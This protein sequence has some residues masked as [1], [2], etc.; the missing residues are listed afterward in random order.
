MKRGVPAIIFTLLLA[1]IAGGGVLSTVESTKT[2]ATGTVGQAGTIVQAADPLTLIAQGKSLLSA[3]DILD[4]RNTFRQAVA[5]DP[6]NQE[7]NLLYGVTRVFAVYEDGQALNT[8]GLDSV[9]EILEL[10]GVVFSSFNL[11]DTQ[12]TKPRTFA[13]TTPSTGAVL[14]FLNSKLLPEINGAIANLAMVTNPSFSSVINPSTINKGTGAAITVDYADALVISS[15]L[16]AMKCNL[17]LLMVYGLDASLP[18]IQAAPKQLM[19]Y[20]QLFQDTTFLTPKN[21]SSLATA[22]TALVAFIDTYNAA[23]E[24]LKSRSGAG[25]HL[26]V[27]DVPVTDEVTSV[28]SLRLDKIR[29]DLADLKTGLNGTYLLP[30]KKMND[31]DR[32]IDLSK[33][34]NS[35][36]PINFRSQIANC[37]SKLVLPDPTMGGLFPLGLSASASSKKPGIAGDILGVACTGYNSETPLVKFEPNSILISDYYGPRPQSLTISNNGTANLVVSAV[38]L[39]GLNSSEFNFSPGNCSSLPATLTPGSSCT[40][41]VDLNNPQHNYLS[42]DIQ[43]D[44]NDVSSPHSYVHL[45]GYSTASG[46]N[47]PPG[48]LTL[49]YAPSPSGTGSGSIEFSVNSYSISYSDT[50]PGACLRQIE[51]GGDIQIRP[52]PSQG[53]LFAGWSGCDSAEGDKC[54]VKMYAA[55]TVNATFNRDTTPLT[56]MAYPPSG[57]YAGPQSVTLSVSK[58]ATIYYTLDNTPPTVASLRYTGPFSITAPATLKY[59]AIDPFNA[60][61]GVKTE[62]YTALQQNATLTVTMNGNGGGGT[63]NSILPVSGLIICSAPSQS[64]DNCSTTQPSGTVVALSASEDSTSL[65][66]GWSLTSCPGTGNC[67][68]TLDANTSVTGTFTAMPPVELWS[69]SVITHYTQLQ[70]AYN[71]AATNSVIL[72]TNTTT[73]GALLA[74]NPVSITIMGGFD[75]G[76]NSQP[77][78]S[79]MQGILTIGLGNATIEGLIVK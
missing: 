14:T 15:F 2:G 72:L 37:G 40:A 3:H 22:K 8:T 67:L 28:T 74:G 48:T 78:Y 57:A 53:S 6:T 36:S 18:S 41:Q 11:Y 34:F 79:V 68:I 1:V 59:I 38:S 7:A 43:F 32:F 30:V 52:V 12:Y 69:D 63:I 56:V 70:D 4:A 42:A 19:T 55:K 21:A 62:T 17:E 60:N 24:S 33:F 20:K 44:T 50:C 58:Q 27:V 61:S 9:R 5:A 31:Q 39:V 71:S 13:G 26:F 65:F 45:T 77:G 64:G 75:A 76:F 49:T 35:A 10:S 25:H 46:G 16:Q 73:F 66:T 54:K 51:T 29:S 23:A 47:Q